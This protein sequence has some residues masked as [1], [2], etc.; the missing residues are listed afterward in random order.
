[1]NRTLKVTRLHLNK[2]STFVVAPLSIVGLVM[3]VSMIIA[4]AIQRSGAGADM[5]TYVEGARWNSGIVWSLPGFLIYYGV[6][7]VAT[8]YP[9]GLALGATRRNF[10]LGTMLANALQAAYITLVLLILLGLEVATNHWFMSVYV[11]DVNALGA[12]NPLILA[13]TVFLGVMFCLTIGGFFGAIWVRFGAKGPA[14]V[15]GGIG[16]L[17][18]VTIL[19]LAPNLGSIFAGITGLGVAL[20]AIVVIVVALFVTWLAMRRAS[21]R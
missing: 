18:A 4:L 5:A 10:V 6:Q 20:T 11:L 19:I 7:A 13:A 3:V 1:M 14:V 15:G 9:F 21:V 12:G 2:L 16:L 17:L 8:T